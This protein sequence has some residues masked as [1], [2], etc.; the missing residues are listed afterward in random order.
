MI[1][2]YTVIG[3]PIAHS[4][5]PVVHQ[6]FGELTQRKIHYT[7][8]E[9][10]P[11]TFADTVIDWQ[12]SGARG[13][14]VTAPF[15]ELAVE[16]SDRLSP[17]ALRAGSV[18]TIHMHRDGSRVGHNTDGL[19]L[20]ADIQSN[21]RRPLEGQRI[22][23]LGAGGAAR[24]VM[25]PLLATKPALLHVANRTASKAELLSSLFEDLGAVSGSGFE[26]LEG[27]DKFD[28]VINATTVS[29]NG[30]LPPLPEDIISHQSLAYD[31][32]YSTRDTLF[33]GW[34]KARGASAS[35]GL[36]ML[37]EQ[38]AEAFLIW[39]GVRPKTRMAFPRLRE[40]IS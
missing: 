7:R 15:K 26:E 12:K 28:I 34:C 6:L 37:V 35:N 27:W 2:R 10:S 29:M 16:V 38:A 31:M 19:G 20:V 4:L 8:T 14:N 25:A 3:Q 24:G 17:N 9:A 13:C 1:N 5:S 32:T 30:G 23:L 40:L 11:E 21:L 33:M 22:L 18:N 36:G 39:E